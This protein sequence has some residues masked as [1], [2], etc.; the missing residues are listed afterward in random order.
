MGMAVARDTRGTDENI[1]AVIGD[2]ALTG[3]IA[4]EA[5]NHIGHEQ[6]DLIVILNDNEMS[7]APNVGA[8]HKVLG[9]LRTAGKYHKAKDELEQLL[10]KIPAVGGKIAATAERL[11]DSLKYLLVPGMFFEE[12]GFTYLGP[13]DGHNLENLLENIKYAKKKQKVL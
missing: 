7:I 10:K 4:L 8:L 6:K 11:K 3:G 9:R 13:V 5:L 1:I 12:M 2:G